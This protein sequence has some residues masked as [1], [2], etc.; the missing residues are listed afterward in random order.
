MKIYELGDLDDILKSTTDKGTILVARDGKL[1]GD[2]RIGMDYL[3]HHPNVAYHLGCIPLVCLGNY[4]MCGRVGGVLL[5]K[6][7]RDALM[8]RFGTLE[9]RLALTPQV[10]S[11]EILFKTDWPFP[12]AQVLAYFFA[13]LIP[14]VFV[15]FCIAVFVF[16]E[17]LLELA[18]TYWKMLQ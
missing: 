15:L 10:L 1:I 11:S 9:M 13:R 12:G 8:T 17:R 2:C 6:Q 3:R 14:F 4:T 18:R 5:T 7:V 16:R